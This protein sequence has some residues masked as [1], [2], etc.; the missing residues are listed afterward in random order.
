MFEGRVDILLGGHAPL[1]GQR[2]LGDDR[3]EDP[4]E[5]V[6]L[7]IA[8]CGIRGAGDEVIH[9]GAEARTDR[10]RLRLDLDRGGR[11]IRLVCVDPA[12][13]LAAEVTVGGELLL[14][15]AR[16]KKRRTAQGFEDLT[17]GHGV[18]VLAD[19]VRQR[20]RPHP[21]AAEIA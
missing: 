10:Q 11:G 4:A 13:R 19:E 20:K 17:R 9:C 7:K 6:S 2:R 14:E 3:D 12:S 18:D 16:G 5:Y 21:E 1:I 15:R 8:A